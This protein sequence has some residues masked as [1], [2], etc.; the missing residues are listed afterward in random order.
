[1]KK[2]LLV[3]ALIAAGAVICPAQK[4]GPHD[5]EF[6]AFY[7]DFQKAVKANDKEKIADLIV[8][9]VDDWS[10]ERNHDVTTI[11]IKDRAEFLA[12][13][14]SFF[15]PSMRLHA[16]RGKPVPL[17]DGRYSLI[18]HDTDSEFSF[19]FEYL[20]GTGFRVRSYNIGPR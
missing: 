13:F 3:A 9:P 12:K 10:V 6:Q 20:A 11:A 19:E 4:P 1:M 15:T 17:Q 2:A 14:N 18:W 16:Q 8:F 7:A 5:A